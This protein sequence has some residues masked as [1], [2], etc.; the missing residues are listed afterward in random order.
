MMVFAPNCGAQQPYVSGAIGAGGQICEPT[1]GIATGMAPFQ[2][3]FPGRVWF[4]TNF[5]DQAVG[6]EGIYA[7]FG[8][9][10]R[11]CEDLLDGRWLTEARL[12][13]SLDGGGFF[14]NIGL[15]RVF[16]IDAA[17]ADVTVGA[18]FDYDAGTNADFTHTFYQVGVNASIKSR[19]WDLIGNGY[20]PTDKTGYTQGD[21][22]GNIPFF[23]TPYCLDTWDRHRVGR[24]RHDV[25]NSA[26][27]NCPFERLHRCWWLWLQF[28]HYQLLCRR[29]YAI[30]CPT[31]G[32][33]DCLR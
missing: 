31:L 17:N 15:E 5:A 4:G 14:T 10:T 26:L 13:Q 9:K 24:I 8:L 20:F 22:S 12:H 11:L 30:E 7:S 16:S 27:C 2:M 23:P 18:W 25:E 6:S 21:P 29:S 28:R 3:P 33:F 32:W 19:N 1:T